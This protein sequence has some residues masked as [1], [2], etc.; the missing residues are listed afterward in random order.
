MFE[1]LEDDDRPVFPSTPYNEEVISISLDY[2]DLL[3]A[4]SV[5]AVR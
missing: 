2:L 3:D 4:Q 5:A 1:D